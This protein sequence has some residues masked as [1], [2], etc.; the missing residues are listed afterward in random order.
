M[1]LSSVL[2]KKWGILI[3][4]ESESLIFTGLKIPRDYSINLEDNMNFTYE[5]QGSNTFLVYEVGAEEIVDTMSRGMITNNKIL[6]L[7]PT[8]FFQQ[9]TAKYFKYNISSKVP[10]DQFL[11]GV[12]NKKRLIGVFQGIVDAMISAGD[13]MIDINSICL[14]LKYIFTDVSTCETIL[15]CIPIMNLEKTPVDLKMFFKDIVYNTQFDSTENNDYFMKLINY[16]NGVK[17]F[18]LLDFKALLDEIER[19]VTL[20]PEPVPPIVIAP[21][22]AEINEGRKQEPEIVIPVQNSDFEGEKEIEKNI[23]ESKGKKGGFVD[24]LKEIFKVSTNSEKIEKNSKNNT[25]EEF[26]YDIPNNEETN[27]TDIPVN[28]NTSNSSGLPNGGKGN[29]GDTVNLPGKVKDPTIVLNGGALKQEVKPYLIRCKN[30]EKVMVDKPLFRIGRESEYVDYAI[31][32][33]GAISASHANIISHD[34]EYFVVDINSTNHTYV[35]GGM[36]SSNVET[37]ISN[38]TKIR[39]ADEDFEF[40]LY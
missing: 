39:F 33:N 7:A 19:E 24:R 12:V 27:K 25:K 9:D 2:T 14:D 30:N 22:P 23:S 40:K 5:N 1:D 11:M 29:F 37:K 26:P 15:I 3:K 31:S 4:K 20:A 16:L 13:Y 17:V 10:A 36:L 38:G 28:P 21:I 18:S 32:D 8:I 35:N 6:G 34:G